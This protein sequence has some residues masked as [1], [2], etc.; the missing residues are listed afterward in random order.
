ML[1]L[2]VLNSY[3][4]GIIFMILSQ[5]QTINLNQPNSKIDYIWIW[6]KT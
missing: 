1:I 6:N 5:K 3:L 4:R 2:F